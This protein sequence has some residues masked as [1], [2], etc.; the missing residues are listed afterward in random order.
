[1]VS[2][3][4]DILV[5]AHQRAQQTCAKSTPTSA[6]SAFLRNLLPRPK[7]EHVKHLS[8]HLARDIGL[9]LAQMQVHRHVWPSESTNHPRL[10]SSFPCRR[11]A[12]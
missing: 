8:N 6:V 5:N 11:S 9:S 1:M 3:V 2:T 7:S 12:L 4:S 10:W